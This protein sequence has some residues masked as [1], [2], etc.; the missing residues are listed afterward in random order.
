MENR[1]HAIAAGSF[2]LVLLGLLVALAVWLTRDTGQYRQFEISSHEVVTGLQVQAGVRYK[3]VTVG[4]VQAIALDPEVAGNVLIRLA[5]DRAAPV[6]KSTFSS[7]G[8]QGVTGLAFVQLDD[9]GKSTEALEAEGDRLP[10]IPMRQGLMAKLSDKGTDLLNQLDQGARRMNQLLDEPNQKAIALAIVNLGQAAAS[11]HQLAQQ[12]QQSNLPA[13]A[14]EGRETLAVLRATSERLSQSSQSVSTSAATFKLTNERMQA[15]GG[16]LDQIQQSSMVLKEAGDAVTTT[17]IP[18]L[19]RTVDETG[20]AVR[21]LGQAAET[22]K[23]NP[24]ALLL[25]GTA[26]PPGPGEAGFQAPTK[27]TP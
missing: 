14:K 19:N 23:D 12:A 11:I 8:F 22:L 15:S 10:R 6:T 2:V 21:Q 5:V 27:A 1:S 18:R 13:L 7:L 24:Q 17:L 4:R 20:R 16:M 9:D 26:P 25:G 3:G